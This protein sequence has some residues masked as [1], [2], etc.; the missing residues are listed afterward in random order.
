MVG[1]LFM[2]IKGYLKEVETL[3]GIM[4]HNV[5][6]LGACGGLSAPKLNRKTTVQ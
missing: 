3:I 2:N 6:A 4:Q 5:P 1:L